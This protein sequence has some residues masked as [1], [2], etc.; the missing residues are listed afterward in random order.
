MSKQCKAHITLVEGHWQHKVVARQ[1]TIKDGLEPRFRNDI[2]IFIPKLT[3]KYT[4]PCVF[5][6]VKNRYSR[7]F[8]RCSNPFELA[9]T[10]EELAQT[11]RSDTWLDKWDRLQEVSEKLIVDN[12]FVDNDY[13]DIELFKKDLLKD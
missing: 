13:L 8:L 12:L 2:T 4:K 11:L 9:N 6:H 10:L 3:P 7:C 5:F 1:V